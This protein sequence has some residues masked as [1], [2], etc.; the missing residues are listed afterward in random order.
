MTWILT[1]C[2]PLDAFLATPIAPTPTETPLPTATI[3]WFPAS[4]TPTLQV[5]STQPPT[6]E[7]RPGVG[8]EILSDD[9][10]DPSLWNIS[11]SNQ[12]SAD[13][14]NNRLTL[15]VQSQVFIPSLRQAVVPNNYYAEITARPSL[16]RGEDNY[17]L[18]VR[19]S[20]INYYRFALACN[21][22]VRAERISGGTRLVLQQPLASGDVPPGAPGEVRIGV[23]AVGKE[24]RLFLNGRFQFSV[25][26]PS[27]PSGTLGVF[28]RSAG[29]TAAVVS[30]SDLSIQS[31]DYIPPTATPMP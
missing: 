25:I 5:L 9:F 10:S 24:M 16:C 30:F 11:S 28:V 19:A 22:T 27:F 15:S 7:M 12:A 6:P 21:G 2:S 29:N 17:G 14:K 26:D 8:D 1:S 20:T 13:I 18:L 4:A 3:N 31:V 23:W